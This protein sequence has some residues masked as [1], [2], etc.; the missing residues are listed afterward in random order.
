[1]NYHLRQIIL[2]L[3]FIIL[4]L[5]GCAYMTIFPQPTKG[6]VQKPYF[7]VSYN[8]A[9]D[10]VLDVLGDEGVGIAYQVKENGRIITGYFTMTLENAHAQ[11]K[12][13]WSYTLTFTR[14]SEDKTIIEIV[15]KIEQYL[16]DL[17]AVGYSWRDITGTSGYKKIANDLE[18]WLYEKIE[19]RTNDLKAESK[20]LQKPVKAES[21]LGDNKPSRKAETKPE[22]PVSYDKPAGKVE[23]KAESLITAD[24]IFKNIKAIVLKNGDVIE[25]QI[26]SIDHDALKIRTKK[27]NIASY[28]FM[29]EVSEYIYQ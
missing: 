26:I 28:S 4:T 12:V 8:K 21:P 20:P 18:K 19:K 16:K 13:R 9:R 5:A 1:M 7:Q 6:F 2:T 17:G 11:T 29:N 22:P 27:G 3:L 24:P 23:T 25:G 14:L 10:T 15:C